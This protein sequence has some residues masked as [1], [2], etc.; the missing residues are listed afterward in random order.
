MTKMTDTEG[1][2]IPLDDDGYELF[3][4]TL[5]GDGKMSMS[6][7]WFETDNGIYKSSGY[8]L[9]VDLRDILQECLCDPEQ[10]DDADELLYLANMLRE[11]AD[12]YEHTAAT[13]KTPNA[14]L[15]GK[16]PTTEL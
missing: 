1:A 3:D 11:F 16:P 9:E 6:A 7:P 10:V 4:L 8:V 5:W 2:K 12:S 14:V 15:N 13:R